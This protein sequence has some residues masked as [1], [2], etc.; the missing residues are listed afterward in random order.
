MADLDEFNLYKSLEILN[1]LWTLT[2]KDIFSYVNHLEET[3][4]IFKEI[5]SMG[6]KLILADKLKPAELSQLNQTGKK[7]APEIIKIQAERKVAF[8]NKRF[9]V[10]SRLRSKENDLVNEILDSYFGNP[11][12][13]FIYQYPDRKEILC[14]TAHYQFQI[15]HFIFDGNNK[16]WV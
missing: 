9:D 8:E 6:Y 1:Q 16:A 5:R 15:P 3:K 13:H 11:S 7:N 4:N 10:V 14:R 12:I 2:L